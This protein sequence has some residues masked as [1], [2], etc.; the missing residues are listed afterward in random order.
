LCWRWGNRAGELLEQ[1][2]ARANFAEDS[3]TLCAVQHV[4]HA[5]TAVARN[6]SDY[7]SL[8]AGTTGSAC[9]V[10]V[11]LVFLWWVNLNY[12][13]NVINVNSTSGNIRGNKN[14]NVALD[15]TLKVSVALVLV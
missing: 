8:L 4:F 14:T 1:R 7:G 10:Q 2:V 13:C 6:Q 9:A 12:Q 3:V 15:E 11:S 5:T